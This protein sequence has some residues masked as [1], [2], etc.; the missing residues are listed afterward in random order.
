MA[1]LY[2]IPNVTIFGANGGIQ[3]TG[4][5]NADMISMAFSD[6]HDIVEQHNGVN[7]V[8]GVVAHNQRGDLTLTFYPLP[9]AAATTTTSAGV[10]VDQLPA[11]FQAI[12]LPDPLSTV[13]VFRNTPTP[14]NSS[15][16]WVPDA[17]AAGSGTA[18]QP[19]GGTN[20]RTYHYVGGGSMTL[21]PN[22]LL[23]MTLPL[24]RWVK[25]DT[26]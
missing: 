13:Y 11:S 24:R 6:D 9:G 4:I 21:Q 10:T 2:T 14:S 8:T 17:V 26:N 18:G 22:G 5:A 19:K 25:I 12:A 15:P 23:T 20:Y 3:I 1:D 7:A 16:A